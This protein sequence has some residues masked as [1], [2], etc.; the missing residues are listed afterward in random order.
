MTKDVG[1]W[2]KCPKCKQNRLCVWTSNKYCASCTH[3]ELF[4]PRDLMG[5]DNYV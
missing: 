1:D 5:L 2:K 4:V 3:P